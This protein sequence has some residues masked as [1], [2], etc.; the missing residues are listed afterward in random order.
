VDNGFCPLLPGRV[1]PG[2][3]ADRSA[4]PEGADACCQ[5]RQPL[6]RRA[7][8]S[9][10]SPSGAIAVLPMGSIVSA[11]SPTSWASDGSIRP[12]PRGWRPWQHAIATPWLGGGADTTG[13]ANRGTRV[14][15]QSRCGTRGGRRHAGAGTQKSAIGVPWTPYRT[16][17]S[18]PDGVCGLLAPC[19]LRPGGSGLRILFRPFRA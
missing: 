9:P 8:A 12:P 11:L 17:A 1:E 13:Q 3:R 2:L 6:D 16:R 15:A 4:G 7:S 10:L 14:A 5:G 19:R 18:R